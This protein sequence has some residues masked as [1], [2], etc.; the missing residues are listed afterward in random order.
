M[1]FELFVHLQYHGKVESVTKI[2]C[3]N[4]HKVFLVLIGQETIHIQ[5]FMGIWY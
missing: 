1:R 3:T 4:S 5:I 2:K